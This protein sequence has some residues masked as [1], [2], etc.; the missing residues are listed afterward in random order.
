VCADV[1][2]HNAGT[3]DLEVPM[4]II[5]LPRIAL[6]PALGKPAPQ[7]A[8]SPM[9]WMERLA[10]WAEQGPQHHRLGSWTAAGIAAPSSAVSADARATR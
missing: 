5:S 10:A 6:A 8:A 7:S 1:D 2:C 4:N 3:V 9:S